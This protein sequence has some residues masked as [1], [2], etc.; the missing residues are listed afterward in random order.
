MFETTGFAAAADGTYTAEG[1]LTLRGI[2]LP[3]ILSFSFAETAGVARV[4]GRGTVRR[5]AF[6]IGRSGAP[7]EGWLKDPVEIVFS[8]VATRAGGSTPG[9]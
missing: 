4:E 1:T 8:L 3:V 7:D 6:G 9:S 5:L 2:A